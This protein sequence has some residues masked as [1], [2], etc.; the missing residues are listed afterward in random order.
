MS[1]SATAV[2]DSN[3]RISSSTRLLGSSI[4]SLS[5]PRKSSSVISKTYKEATELFVT[6][7]LLEAHA[8]IEPLVSVPQLPEDT[9]EDHDTPRRAP[10][11]DANR[12]WRI[13]IWAF[14][15]TLLN[16]IAE[17]GPENGKAKFG[18]KAW[19]NLVAK[20]RDGTVWEEVVNVGYGGVEE[21][22]DAEVVINLATLLLAQSPTQTS[23]QQHLE[24]YLSNS[25]SVGDDIRDQIEGT[26][27]SIGDPDGTSHQKNGTDTPRDLETRVNIIELYTLHV[28]P[29]NGEHEYARKFIEMSEVLDEETREVFLQDLESLDKNVET[30]EGSFMDSLPPEE[31]LSEHFDA[32]NS[33]H[34]SFDTVRQQPPIRSESEKDFGIDRP[35]ALS[36]SFKPSTLP[37]QPPMEQAQAQ[38]SKPSRAPPKKQSRKPAKTGTQVGIYRRGAAFIHALQQVVLRTTG[39][40]SQNPLRL[41]R[42]LVFLLGFILTASR[43]DVRDRIGRLTGD[44]WDKLRRTVGMGV[45]VSYI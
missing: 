16:A 30:E 8:M 5:S 15:L 1:I 31:N 21:N 39:Q 14:Y 17:L 18:D 36:Q 23:N 44:G 10:I 34:G 11:A 2:L 9:S 19:S 27:Y 38:Q 41:F 35:E 32:N 43:Q 3:E 20:A 37:P 29:R 13:K 45:K 12:K 25:G 6:R 33:R 42:L 24:I 26:E 28:L 22:I 4:D 40:V 7:R